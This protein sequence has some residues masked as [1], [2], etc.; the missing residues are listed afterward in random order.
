MLAKKLI[1]ILLFIH[2]LYQSRV[3]MQNH[4]L[5]DRK[6]DVPRFISEIYRELS[7]E[8]NLQD[9][10]TYYWRGSLTQLAFH[11]ILQQIFTKPMLI[12]ITNESEIDTFNG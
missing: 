1:W 10:I 5:E 6:N 3:M 7:A 8:I 11:L 12:C 9:T 4:Q 2:P